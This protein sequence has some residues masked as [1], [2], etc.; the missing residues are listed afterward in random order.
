M[1][2]FLYVGVGQCGNKFV[3]AFALNKNTAVAVNTTQ[4]D[5][6]SLKHLDRQNL[7]NI[8]ANGSKGGAGKTPALGAKAMQEHID[9]VYARLMSLGAEADYFFLWAGLGGGTGSGGLPVLLKRL[10]EN[11]K[12][13]ILGLTLPDDT[14]GVEVQVNAFNACIQILKLI[15]SYKVPYLLIENNKIKNK[16]Q[17]V[18]SIDWATV[19]G[20]LS[21]TFTQFNK[22][23]N[24]TSPYSTFDETDF[25]K[26][27]YVKGMM[28]LVRVALDVKDIQNDISLRD[29][30]INAWTKDNYFVDFDYATASI[31][32][33]IIEAPE[34]FLENK[35]NY[36]LIESSLLKLR[37]A[38]GTISPYTGIYPYNERKESRGNKIV[39]Y[40]MLTGL[41]APME[42]LVALQTKAKEEQEAMQKK[43]ESNSVDFSE[44]AAI[45]NVFDTESDDNDKSLSGLN[46]LDSDKEPELDFM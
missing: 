38:C 37:D 16:M 40:S 2:N 5:M 14:E 27:L 12:K 7:V 44:F 4:K 18:N 15:E 25:K 9:D 23:A 43:K 33:T 21:K 26:T 29:A 39:V 24:K 31:M 11:K 32:T 1:L 36:K 13:V 22:S 35:S 42:K 28:S 41:K 3:D 10:L 6:E 17:Q 8:T 34:D 30:I 19:N 20:I 45:G 46:A